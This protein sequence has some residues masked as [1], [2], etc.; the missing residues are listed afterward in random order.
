[1]GLFLNA[2]RVKS[3]R[4]H[5]VV[6]DRYLL[7]GDI[8]I[9]DQR[10]FR[11]LGYGD[12]PCGVPVGSLLEGEKDAFPGLG[13]DMETLLPVGVVAGDDDRDR[14]AAHAQ[15]PAGAGVDIQPVKMV[16]GN[17]SWGVEMKPEGYADLLKQAYWRKNNG[18]MTGQRVG[19]GREK[20]QLYGMQTRKHL[21]GMPAD[22]ADQREEVIGNNPDLN[23]SPLGI[24]WYAA[25][26]LPKI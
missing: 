18:N 16:F 2:Q 8:V 25:I 6:N 19:S 5:G 21:K 20:Q 11:R 12:D 17:D 23:N 9:C 4:V 24:W 13:A 7:L 14:E 15:H 3:I 22:A 26:Q 1:M 10:L